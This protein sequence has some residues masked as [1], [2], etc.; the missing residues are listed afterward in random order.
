MQDT[1]ADNYSDVYGCVIMQGVIGSGGF[2]DNTASN[3][4]ITFPACVYLQKPSIC[5]MKESASTVVLG[6]QLGTS[7]APDHPLCTLIDTG[8]MNEF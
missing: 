3:K 8:A 4:G 1:N 5:E 7:T 2:V 6:G